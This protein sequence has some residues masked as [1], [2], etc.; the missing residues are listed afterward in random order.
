M[1][2]TLQLVFRNEEGGLFTLNIPDPREDLTEEDVTA[3]MD[4]VLAK[5][6]FS[7]TGGGLVS[8]VRARIATRE[9]VD[10]VSFEA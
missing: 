7:G 4:L 3:V 10:F 1:E 6:V 8:K 5:G 9:T 2:K